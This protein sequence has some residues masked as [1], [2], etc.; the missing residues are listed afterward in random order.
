M[1]LSDRDRQAVQSILTAVTTPV[2][3]LFFTQSIGCEG[4]DATKEILAE[5]ASLSDRIA[6]EEVNYVLDKEKVATHGIDSVPAIAVVT[7]E[8]AARIRF[9][10]VPSGYEFM[11]LLD[12]IVMAG[13]GG[14]PLAESS[15][16]LAAA[17]KSPIA[18]QVFVTP[19]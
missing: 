6:I 11:S 4:C 3:I 12:A 7:G 8:G 9:Y 17:V 16:A 15:L 13:G 1:L 18:F 5:V 2:R 19:T 14:T 10:G